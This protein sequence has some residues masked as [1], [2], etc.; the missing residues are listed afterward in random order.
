MNKQ[1]ASGSP[2]INKM[3]TLGAECDRE[4]WIKGRKASAVC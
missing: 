2:L 3:I 1:Q 4:E